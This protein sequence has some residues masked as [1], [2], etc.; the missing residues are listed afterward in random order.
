MIN[1]KE[2]GI[3]HINI[4]SKGKTELGRLLSNFAYSPV[5][6]PDGKFE[7]LEGYWYWLL[8]DQ[9]K[10]AEQLKRVYGYDAKVLGRA[11]KISDWPDPQILPNF[12]DRFKYAMLEKVKQN[13]TIYEQLAFSSLPFK[14]YYNY[15]EKVVE[16]DCDWMVQFWEEIRSRVQVNKD[17]LI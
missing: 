2:D 6:L 4:Y 7:S 9:D 10:E 15:G 11:L 14:H 13:E 5:E 16:V 17:D 8:S 3:T 12:Q 1:P